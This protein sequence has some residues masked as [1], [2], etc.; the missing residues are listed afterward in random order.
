MKILVCVKQVPDPDIELS[1][2]PGEKWITVPEKSA[3]RMNR[4]DA[5]A[6]EEALGIKDS[7]PA[8]SEISIDCVSVGSDNVRAILRRSLALGADSAFHIRAADSGCPD[9][10]QTAALI[11]DLA[12]GHSYN[13]ILAG[14]MAEDDMHGLVGAL[15]AEMLGYPCA[16]AVMSQEIN[17]G[18]TQIEVEREIEAGRR[19][20]VRLRLPAVLTIQ[21]GI[22][23]PRYP[24]LSSLLRAAK[25]EIAT[26]DARRLTGPG[27]S[28]RITALSCPGI[29]A[30]G[31]FLE[32]TPPDKARALLDVFH[33]HSFI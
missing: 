32:G 28:V 30:K 31:V 19:E 18:G 15:V 23:T 22:N 1:I 16:T 12:K 4:Y 20:V 9:P 29:P 3:L 17:P 7:F 33:A 10:F 11:A 27:R 14:L 24:A 13:L 26:I 6:L 2:A 5:F 8:S 25:Q 21:S